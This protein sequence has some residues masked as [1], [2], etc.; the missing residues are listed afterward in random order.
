M[1]IYAPN[2][3]VHFDSNTDFVGAISAK[4]VSFDSNT[5]VTW[6][7]AAANVQTPVVFPIL[8]EGVYRECSPPATPVA[9]PDSR[10]A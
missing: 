6:D 1:T 7:D 2:S 5:T 9:G 3:E 10:H 4:E 8:R